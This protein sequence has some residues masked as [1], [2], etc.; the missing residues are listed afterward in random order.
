MKF[1]DIGIFCAKKTQIPCC[2]HALCIGWTLQ[3]HISFFK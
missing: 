1:K 2:G 3:A